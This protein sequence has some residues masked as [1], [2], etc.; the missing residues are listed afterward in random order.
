MIPLMPTMAK[1]ANVFH[2]SQAVTA[3]IGIDDS[4]DEADSRQD[5]KQ[6]TTSEHNICCTSK[7]KYNNAHNAT[8]DQEL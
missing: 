5:N 7:P 4:S 6:I 2:A 3:T 1:G 8:L